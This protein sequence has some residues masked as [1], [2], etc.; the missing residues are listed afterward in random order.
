MKGMVHMINKLKENIGSV[1]VGKENVIDLLLVSQYQ[2]RLR[3]VHVHQQ[4]VKRAVDQ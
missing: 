2:A 4:E 3:V 1:F